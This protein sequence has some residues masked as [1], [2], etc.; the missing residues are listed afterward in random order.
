V[1]EKSGNKDFCL[2]MRKAGLLAEIPEEE[3][4]IKIDTNDKQMWTERHKPTRINELVGNS[5]VVD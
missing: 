4:V 2:S 5:A 1:R 3:T